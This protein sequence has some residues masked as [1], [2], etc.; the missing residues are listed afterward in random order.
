MAGIGFTCTGAVYS[1][2]GRCFHGRL[3]ECGVKGQVCAC[4]DVGVGEKSPSDQVETKPAVYF[5]GP[6]SE[7]KCGIPC[8][9]LLGLSGQSEQ[10]AKASSAFLSAESHVMS[11]AKCPWS[12]PGME[13]VYLLSPLSLPL[14]PW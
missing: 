6:G 4:A 3:Y 8:S 2:Q 10:H 13:N 11:H 1:V 14:L 7:W 9:K 5:I 12:L